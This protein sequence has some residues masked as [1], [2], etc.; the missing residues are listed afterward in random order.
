MLRSSCWP[1]EIRRLASS[2]E[3]HSVMPWAF[4]HQGPL[5][6]ANKGSLVMVQCWLHACLIWKG[7]TARQ[8]L[9][10]HD[11]LHIADSTAIACW[12]AAHLMMC[13]TGQASAT[14]FTCRWILDRLKT[15][16]FEGNKQYV[17]ELLAILLQTSSENQRRVAAANGI[18]ILLQA[19]APY[20]S[21]TSSLCGAL[22]RL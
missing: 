10:C 22:S 4:L 8:C 5:P 13:C 9:A 12:A 3:W 16:E 21:A 15:R 14:D 18:D 17:A 7:P 6:L 1:W 19:L 2:S 11:A 20:R